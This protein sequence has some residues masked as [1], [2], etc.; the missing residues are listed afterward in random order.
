MVCRKVVDN[1][2]AY[3][4]PVYVWAVLIFYFSSTVLAGPSVSGL[5]TVFLIPDYY[6]HALTYGFFTF[7]LWRA[8][9]NSEFRYPEIFAVIIAGVYGISDELHQYFVPGRCCSL[10]DAL[11]NFVGGILVQPLIL[12][13]KKMLSKK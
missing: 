3:W 4:F 1:Q 6:K 8:F 10:F 13:H 12:L 5:G 9:R 11:S 7:L 2:L